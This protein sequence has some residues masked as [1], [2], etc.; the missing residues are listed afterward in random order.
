MTR[1]VKPTP[2]E[3]DTARDSLRAILPAGSKVY[4]IRRTTRGTR[5]QISALIMVDGEP[6]DVSA[7]VARAIGAAWTN[8]PHL[9]VC[10][11]GGGMDMGFG[12]V[13]DLAHALY[14]DGYALTR[15][16]L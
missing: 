2:A 15:V 5:H 13:Y 1:T 8:D 10:L 3:R 14:G 4:T 11:S 7:K 16:E 9:A 12:L 6:R